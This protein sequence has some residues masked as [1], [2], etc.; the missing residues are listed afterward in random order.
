MKIFLTSL[1]FCCLLNSVYCQSDILDITLSNRMNNNR[2][3]IDYYSQQKNQRT[4]D[5]LYFYLD[6]NYRFQDKLFYRDLC[7][8]GYYYLLKGDIL[9]ST[10]AISN[11]IASGLDSNT[12]NRFY[13]KIP[14]YKNCIE[15]LLF[16]EYEKLRGIYYSKIDSQL[17]NT[18]DLLL[19]LDKLLRKKLPDYAKSNLKQDCESLIRYADSL[20][21]VRV[22]ELIQTGNGI[23]KSRIGD[24]Q[25]YI[26]L[27]MHITDYKKEDYDFIRDYCVEKVPKSE[28]LIYDLLKLM[29]RHAR[30]NENATLCDNYGFWKNIPV[31]C[32]CTTMENLWRE[33]GLG[34]FKLYL[35]AARKTTVM[36]NGW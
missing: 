2:Y 8:M 31:D 22:R 21:F 6:D 3:N 17:V 26:V 10:I 14:L 15:E 1:V 24:Y 27:L 7:D 23:C 35:R 28:I 5:S 13:D 32:N 16:K 19:G 18:Y 25:D 34:S 11:A 20:N 4:K 29:L 36:C 12:M 33:K 9:K 30:D